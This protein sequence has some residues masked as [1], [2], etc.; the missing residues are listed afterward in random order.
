MIKKFIDKFEKNKH[1]LEDIYSKKHPEDYKEVVKNVIFILSIE[2][3]DDY[4]LPSVERIHEINDGSYQ[5]TLIYVIGQIGYKPDT[6]W[7]CRIAYGSC[8]V[9]DLLQS[10]CKYS[11]SLPNE[12]QIKDY[13]TLSLHI[14]QRLKQMDDIFDAD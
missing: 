5:G 11:S 10:I 9:C 3:D 8:S 6:Y 2:E 1:I 12:K 14:V 4:E 13:M 7:Y